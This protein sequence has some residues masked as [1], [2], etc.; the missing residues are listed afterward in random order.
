MCMNSINLNEA[1]L[2]EMCPD[3]DSADAISRWAQELIDL[4]IQQ[5]CMEKGQNA[6]QED[7]WHA[8]EQN[9]EL[10]LKP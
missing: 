9:P 7:L 6:S 10:T 8:I 4:R 1:T 5:M 3:F 2:R